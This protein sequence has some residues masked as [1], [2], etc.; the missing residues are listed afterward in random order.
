MKAIR[1]LTAASAVTAVILTGLST[2]P[3]LAENIGVSWARFQEERWKSDEAALKARL[4]QL[5]HTLL[6]ADARGSVERQAADIEGLLARGVKVLL[7]VGQDTA[8]VIPAVER[9]LAEGVPVIAYER[10]IKHPGVTYIG[11]DP[12]LVGEAQA[13]ALLKVQPEGN[14]V[15]IKGGQQDQYAHGTYQGQMNVIT[16]AVD[17]GQIKIIAE[18]WTTDWKPEVAQSNM[19]NI[20]TAHGDAIDAVLCSNDGMASG[21]AAALEQA[22]MLGLPLSGQDGD[23]AAVNRIARGAQTMTA[24]KDVRVLGRAAAELAD[25]IVGGQDPMSLDGAT[26]FADA[27]TGIEQAALPLEPVT[28]TIDNIDLMVDAGWVSTEEVCRG[29][30]AGRLALCD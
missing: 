26:T 16:D 7:V 24:W 17:T 22:G 8:A 21:V 10:Q 3:A 11:F 15:L 2:V 9:A 23:I 14:Y 27:E 20:I 25:A 1:I 29:V 4:E 12:V 6:T 13:R 19:E 28:I 18:Q 30:D 5:G